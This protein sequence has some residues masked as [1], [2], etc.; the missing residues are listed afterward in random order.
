MSASFVHPPS[1]LLPSFLCPTLCPFLSPFRPPRDLM[2]SQSPITVVQCP[3]TAPVSPDLHLTVDISLDPLGRGQP[4]S[5][6]RAVRGYHSDHATVSGAAAGEGGPSARGGEVARGRGRSGGRGRERRDA[7]PAP[8]VFSPAPPSPSWGGHSDGTVL[9]FVVELRGVLRGHLHLPRPFATAMEAF[10]PPVLWLRAY[11]CC[12]C[13]MQV[14]VEYTKRRFMLLGRGWKAFAHAHS[15]EDGHVLR[16][17]LVEDDML[18]VKFYGPSDVRLG[19]CEESTSDA[20]CPSSSDI[21]EEDS[22]GGGAR[23]GSGSR[24][25]KLEH[26]TPSSN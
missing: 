5:A 22:G 26:D 9:E 12:H 23:G 14:N 7:T 4:P 1:S 18:S 16:F 24:G 19:Y 25:V 3:A 17:K 11:G 15:L 21:D 20:E 10:K 13:A 8:P 6:A 2:S